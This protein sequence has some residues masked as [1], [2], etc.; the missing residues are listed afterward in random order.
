MNLCCHHFSFK[1]SRGNGVEHITDMKNIPFM[2]NDTSIVNN[3][4]ERR[5]SFRPSVDSLR[6]SLRTIRSPRRT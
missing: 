2:Q 3:T 5:S 1:Y 4:T 6:I